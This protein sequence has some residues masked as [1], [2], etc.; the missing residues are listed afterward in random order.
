MNKPG[1]SLIEMLISSALILF[2]FS[3]AAQLI[4]SSLVAKRNAE[5][6]LAAASLATSK[7]EYF[8][9][10]PFENPVLIKGEYFETARIGFSKEVFRSEWNIGDI[11]EGMK[12]V[13]IK[14][15]RQSDPRKRVV[16]MLLL[17]RE[18]EF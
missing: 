13:V 12:K 9:S 2:L 3:G 10:L 17:C 8:K 18:L 15:S 11:D 7:L 4:M 1:F 14:I 16:F 6:H 5:F